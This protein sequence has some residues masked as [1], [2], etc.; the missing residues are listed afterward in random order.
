MEP[1]IVRMDRRIHLDRSVHQ[2]KTDETRPDGPRYND[3]LGH[4]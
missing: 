1:D 2:T 3:L 4:Q